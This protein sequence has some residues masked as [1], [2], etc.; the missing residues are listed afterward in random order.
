MVR[1]QI[2]IVTVER[3]VI[4][5][6]D[7][8][9]HDDLAAIAQALH[10]ASDSHDVELWK[11]NQRLLQ[12]H[13]KVPRSKTFT[14]ADGEIVACWRKTDSERLNGDVLSWTSFSTKKT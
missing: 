5:S 9:C 11:H 1:Y 8:D 2:R 10:R 3:Q 13:S 12:V 7:L 4:R 6:I 14:E